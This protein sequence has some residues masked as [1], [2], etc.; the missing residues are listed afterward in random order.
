MSKKHYLSGVLILA[1]FVLTFFLQDVIEQIII[2]PALYLF[3]LAGVIYRFIPQPVLWIV[4]LL[5]FAL[6]TVNILIRKMF[7]QDI[8]QTIHTLPVQG[9]VQK[10]AGQIQRKDGGIYFKWN[11]ARTLGHIAMQIQE[12]NLHIHSRTLKLPDKNAAPQIYTYLDAGLNSSFSAY[13]LNNRP[14]LLDT[15]LKPTQTRQAAPPTP[16]D[17]DLDAVLDYLETELENN[18]DIKRA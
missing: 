15:L 3:W 2:R 14:K 7:F 9:P 13:P 6:V 11:T 16:F 12:L 17:T 8:F 10:L 18:D 5:L 1:T 4:L